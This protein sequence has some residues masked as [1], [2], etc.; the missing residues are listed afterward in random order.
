[1]GPPSTPSHML[2]A[3]VGIFTNPGTGPCP[4]EGTRGPGSLRGWE[5]DGF[6]S[7]SLGDGPASLCAGRQ[8]AAQELWDSAVSSLGFWPQDDCRLLN[9][10]WPGPLLSLPRGTTLRN[11]SSGRIRP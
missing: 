1:M 11:L 9:R 3:E 4:I 8:P 2:E 10:V 6:F 5:E 7:R